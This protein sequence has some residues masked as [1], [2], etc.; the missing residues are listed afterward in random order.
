MEVTRTPLERLAAGVMEADRLEIPGT[1]P[2][3]ESSASGKAAPKGL[4]RSMLAQ[5][6]GAFMGGAAAVGRGGQRVR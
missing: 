3:A 2:P 4:A 5:V 1:H 6:R